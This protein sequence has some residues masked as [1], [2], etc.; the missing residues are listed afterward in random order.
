MFISS[1]NDICMGKV[2]LRQYLAASVV[3]DPVE[4]I[5][6]ADLKV[7]SVVDPIQAGPM[8]IQVTTGL[9]PFSERHLRLVVQG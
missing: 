4:Q 7:L 2:E 3:G 1:L 6:P 8:D 5:K 9:K